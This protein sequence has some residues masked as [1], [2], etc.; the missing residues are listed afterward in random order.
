MELEEGAA[1]RGSGDG[2]AGVGL[3]LELELAA[4]GMPAAGGLV[5]R[6]SSGRRRRRELVRGAG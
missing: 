5:P 3:V 6:A 2:P 4:A 1:L